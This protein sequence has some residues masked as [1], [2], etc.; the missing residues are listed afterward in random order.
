MSEP[1]PDP[2]AARLAEA[3]AVAANVARLRSEGRTHLAA[4]LAYDRREIL[5]WASDHR[6]AAVQ[7]NAAQERADRRIAAQAICTD[8]ERALL[9]NDEIVTGRARAVF[10]I[11]YGERLALIKQRVDEHLRRPKKVK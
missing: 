4:N 3:D 5:A 9:A 8:E 7:K 2:N 1:I 11:A 6:G 10:D